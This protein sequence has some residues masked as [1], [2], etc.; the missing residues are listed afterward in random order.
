VTIE[1]DRLTRERLSYEA[2]LENLKTALRE[3]DAEIAALKREVERL[4]E[5]LEIAQPYIQTEQVYVI[6]RVRAALKGKE[7]P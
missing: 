2:E 7:K 5:T 6:D 3:R 4:R 1:I